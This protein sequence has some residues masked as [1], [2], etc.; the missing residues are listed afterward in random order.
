MDYRAFVNKHI[1]VEPFNQGILSGLTF[2]V[3]DV[4]DIKG[5]VAS[6]GN[7][8]WL[9][10]HGNPAEE[11][12]PAIKLLLEN[13]A[14]LQGTTM[15]DELMYSLQGENYHYGTPVN[16]KAPQC[17]PGGSSSGSAVAASAKLVDF[18]IGTDTGGSI[19]VPSAYCGNYGIRPTHGAITMD[20]VIPLAPSFDTI[21]WMTQSADMLLKVGTV[22]LKESSLES[23][24]EFKRF[25]YAQDA[26]D[27][28]DESCKQ[29]MLDCAS[30]L[31]FG[32]APT[33][34]TIAEEG[35]TEWMNTFRLLQGIE[36]WKS[37]GEWIKET[38]PSFGPGISERF[39]W[40][41][42]LS[43]EG[44]EYAIE[45]REKIK[46]QLNKLL[47][48]DGLLIVPTVPG[49]APLLHLSNEEIE[50]GR[51][52][53]LKLSCIAGLAG[54]PQVSIPITELDGIPLGLSIIAGPN[55]DLRLLQWIK[56]QDYLIK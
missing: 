32:E 52:N 26:W 29:K 12:A 34:L 17:I 50:I 44:K 46:S 5:N 6:A 8:D 11:H 27:L 39:Q 35:L 20:G 21:G 3:K 42:T 33:W 15:T 18:A 43:I 37:Q 51:T 24:T 47:G 53:T 19:R 45:L 22:L 41:S 14:T 9:R 10:T 54:L 40:A 7:P 25:M 1:R 2:A 38:K 56:E 23:K 48:E 28:V 13:G 4:F 16:P 55:Q 30:S 31:E 49:K 36:I